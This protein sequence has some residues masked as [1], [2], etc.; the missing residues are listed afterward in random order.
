MLT[1]PHMC[2]D[3]DMNSFP[4]CSIEL[5]GLQESE[6]HLWESEAHMIQSGGAISYPRTTVVTSNVLLSMAFSLALGIIRLEL[7]VT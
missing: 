1:L 7:G 6:A 5:R 4:F 2:A 3:A